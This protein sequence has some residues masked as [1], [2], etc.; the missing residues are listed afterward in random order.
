VPIG[1][2][3]DAVG[4]TLGELG[5]DLLGVEVTAIRR[6]GIRGVEPGPE[7]KLRANDIAVLRGMPDS[8]AKAEESL[9]K[10]RRTVPE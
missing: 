4:R 5:L 9:S 6:H 1:E 2:R 8:L 10:V 3:S 7:T